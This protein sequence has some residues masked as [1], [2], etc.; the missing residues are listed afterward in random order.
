VTSPIFSYPYTRTRDALYQLE[1][2]GDLD[3]CHGIRLK[4]ANPTN[5]DFAIPT[6]ATFM[7]LLP[8]GF[9][10]QTYRSTDATVFSVVEGH[11]RVRVDGKAHSWSPRDTFV[12]PSWCAYRLESDD[13]AVLFSFSDRGVQEKLGLWREAKGVA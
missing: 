3:D 1:R 11:G 6:M 7:Q 13:E 4:Y 10:G 9:E 5:G 12:I 2:A 8:K